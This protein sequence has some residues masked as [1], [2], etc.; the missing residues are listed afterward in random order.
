MT[1]APNY[2]APAR[3]TDPAAALA[4]VTAIYEASVDHLRNALQAFVAARTARAA[5]APAIRSCASTP[6]RWRAPTRA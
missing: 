2:I 3:Y 4:Q 1:V 6:T 5:C